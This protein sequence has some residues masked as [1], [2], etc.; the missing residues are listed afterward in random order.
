[1]ALT[2]RHSFTSVIA[3]DPA[4]AG[5]GEVLPSHWNATHTVTGTVEIADVT[6]LTAALAGKAAAAHTHAIAD[7]MG[8]QTAL[9]AKAAL[10]HS[11]IAAD[12]TDFA[13]AV[14]DRVAALLIAGTNI[15]LTYND[16]ANT[17]TIAAAGSSGLTNVQTMRRARCY[18]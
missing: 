18:T 10:S 14:D 2:V 12:L 4:A 11:H 7:V 13:E 17:L 16:V 6:G 15:T 1:M 9:D 5:A 3:D 8:L